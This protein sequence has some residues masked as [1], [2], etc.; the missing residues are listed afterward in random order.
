MQHEGHMQGTERKGIER[1]LDD[2][3]SESA[4]L[5][6]VKKESRLLLSDRLCKGDAD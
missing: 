5:S 3:N 1:E 2:E 4:E 6:G